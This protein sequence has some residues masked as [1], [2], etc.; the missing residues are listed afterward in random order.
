VEGSGLEG[1]DMD[2]GNSPDLLPPAAVVASMAEG[3]S[4]IGGVEHARSKESDRISVLCRELGRLGIRVKEKKDGLFF[5]GGDRPQA[6]EA[7]S[8]GDHRIAMALAVLGLASDGI[9][10]RDSECVSVSYPNFVEDLV[11]LGAKLGWA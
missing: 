11:G 5:E 4:T 1:V 10:I 2:L 6:G 9:L 7:S 3:E 8:H